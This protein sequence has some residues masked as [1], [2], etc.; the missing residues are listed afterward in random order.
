MRGARTLL[1]V[2]EVVNE[3]VDTAAGNVRGGLAKIQRVKRRL[4]DVK[5]WV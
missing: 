4:N 2:G 3:K 5:R 1:Q